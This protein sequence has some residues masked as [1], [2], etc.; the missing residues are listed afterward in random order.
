MSPGFAFALRVTSRGAQVGLTASIA[1]FVADI[2]SQLVPRHPG[3][4]FA[5]AGGTAGLV[6]W[7]LL[8]R[9]FRW[10]PMVSSDHD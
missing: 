3:L 2:A 10:V 7:Q 5:I 8:G 4:L 9:F 6:A 1:L